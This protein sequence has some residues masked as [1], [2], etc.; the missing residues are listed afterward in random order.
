VHLFF[1]CEQKMMEI[2]CRH[3]RTKTENLDEYVCESAGRFFLKAVCKVCG[4]KKAMRTKKPGPAEPVDPAE[5][6]ITED[7]DDMHE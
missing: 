2:H 1:V 4:A 5:P 6:A 7:T 3:C